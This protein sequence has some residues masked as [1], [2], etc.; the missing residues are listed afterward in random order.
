MNSMEYVLLKA[1]KIDKRDFY[2]L[3]DGQDFSAE[4][5]AERLRNEGWEVE[6]IFGVDL[7]ILL[8]Y[9]KDIGGDW[10]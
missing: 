10:E 5:E 2:V 1:S 3:Y 6:L 7:D 8:Q 9:A 4:E